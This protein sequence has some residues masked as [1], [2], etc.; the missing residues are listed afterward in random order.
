M[1]SPPP[2]RRNGKPAA[3]GPGPAVTVYFAAPL[4]TLLERRA[5]RAL[6]KAIL[7]ELPGTEIYLPQDFK[8]EGKFNESHAFGRIFRDC[9]EHID[10]ADVMLAWLDGPDADSGTAFEVGYAFAKGIPVVGVRTDFRQNQ[11]RGLNIMLARA[12]AAFVYRPSFDEDVE[13]L[14]R[15]IA[16]AVRKVGKPAEEVEGKNV[17]RKT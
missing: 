13:G 10:R 8:H 15:D 5:N 9:V 2:A 14:A 7:R 12:C 17:K 3:A 16:R 4:F 11:E 1:P 6:A